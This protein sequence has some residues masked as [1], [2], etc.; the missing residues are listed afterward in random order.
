MAT[1]RELFFREV[2]VDEPHKYGVH[3]WIH[4]LDIYEKH[5]SRYQN[6][7]PVILEVGVGAGGSL[8]MWRKYFGEGCTIYGVD[9]LPQGYPIEV[10]GLEIL[11]GDQADPTFWEDV[12]SKIPKID[13]F[14]D[15]GGHG[16]E[17]QKVTFEC[18]Y[19]HVKPDGVYM[20]EDT[21]TSYWPGFG[22]YKDPNTFVEY[23]KN[24]VDMLHAW[25]NPVKVP[26]HLEFRKKTHSVHFYDSIVLLEKKEDD[27]EPHHEMR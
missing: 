19:D 18:M 8:E 6:K 23:S 11:Q 20:C 3:K 22:G 5:F 27:V 15:D 17:Q 2:I 9:L 16:M 26:G 14:I 21:H 25:H 24:F 13:I 4:Y 12:K 7:G 1:F 10:E